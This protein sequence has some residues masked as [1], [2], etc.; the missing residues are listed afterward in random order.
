MFDYTNRY[1]SHDKILILNVLNY[2]ITGVLPFHI[3]KEIPN[4]HILQSMMDMEEQ[5]LP[6]TLKIIYMNSFLINQNIR[7]ETWKKPFTKLF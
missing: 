2:F 7:K 1:V 6:I 3:L 4:L 5:A